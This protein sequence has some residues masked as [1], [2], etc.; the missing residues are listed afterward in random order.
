MEKNT[1]NS[2]ARKTYSGTIDGH[3]E[4]AYDASNS[5]LNDCNAV[6]VNFRTDRSGWSAGARC[7]N[8]T[9]L[10]IPS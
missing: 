9:Y 5:G 7:S 4:A 10:N 8:E 1:R 3:P 2:S 6:S